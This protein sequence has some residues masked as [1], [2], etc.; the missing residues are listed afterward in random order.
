M[1]PQDSS[2]GQ[3]SSPPRLCNERMQFVVLGFVLDEAPVTDAE[4]ERGLILDSDCTSER[5]D[6]GNAVN[7]LILAG[8]LRREGRQLWPTRPARI[9]GA[10]GQING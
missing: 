10:I 8:L 5:D 7:E 3:N 6:V 2:E 9:V 4:L 1:H